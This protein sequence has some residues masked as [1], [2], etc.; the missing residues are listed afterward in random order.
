MMEAGALEH[1]RA[2]LAIIPVRQWWARQ[3][4]NLRASGYEPGALPL[5]YGPHSDSNGTFDPLL[6]LVVG[7][8]RDRVKIGIS[9][10]GE[11]TVLRQELWR[12]G[13]DNQRFERK[14]NGHSATP[15]AG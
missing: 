13:E 6:G 2:S 11:V 10:P 5:S 7:V 8:E 12:D 15:Q 9:A 14:E 1:A 3:D 4:S